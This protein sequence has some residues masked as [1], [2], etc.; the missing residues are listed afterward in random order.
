MGKAGNALRTVLVRY[1]ITQNRLAVEMGI[2][3]GTVGNWFHET[4]DPTGDAI[5][6]IVDALLVLNPAAARDFLELYLGRSLN[7]LTNP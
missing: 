4:R 2:S 6:A 1:G 7:D 3:R 5:A